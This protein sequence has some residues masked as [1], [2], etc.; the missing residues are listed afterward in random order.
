MSYLALLSSTRAEVILMVGAFA[1]LFVDLRFLRGQPGKIRRE[2]ALAFGGL[3]IAAAMASLSFSIPTT[4]LWDGV[5]ILDPLTKLVKLVILALAL[6]AVFLVSDSLPAVHVGEYLAVMF[7]GTTGLLLLV[8]TED[9]VMLFIALELTSLSLYLL[10]A[11]ARNDPLSAE[12]ALKYFLFGSVS[13]AFTL[14]GISLL[15]G[16]SGS[17]NLA[18]IAASLG[19]G[20][21]DSLLLVA[22]AM[23]IM[24]LAFKVAAAPLHLWAPD[25]YQGAP[26]SAAAFIASA[27]KV[28][29]FFIFARVML[30]GFAG[31]EGS[32]SWAGMHGGWVLVFAGLSVFSMVLGNFTAL[33]QVSVRR[34]LAYS[35]VAHAG[36]ALL[37]FIPH[38]SQGLSA[39]LYYVITYSLAVAGAFGVVAVVER[40]RGEDQLPAYSGLRQRSPLLAACMLI[41]ILSLAGIPPLPGFFGKFY[42]FAAAVRAENNFGLLWL[43]IVAITLSAL[44]LY[45]Y[46]KVLKQI[47]VANPPVQS[48]PIPLSLPLRAAFIVL[49]ATVLAAGCLPNLLVA[50]LNQAVAGF[51]LPAP[52]ADLRTIGAIDERGHALA[53][54]E[55][56]YQLRIENWEKLGNEN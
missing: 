37:G 3:A 11:F 27:S 8:S 30:I 39:L 41:F 34:L 13:A 9:L 1:F 16:L 46:L 33:A 5:I 35:A 52:L 50:P 42:L 38:N 25:A 12:A 19:P 4:R 22:M 31:Q 32:A 45:Y 54:W 40:N 49:A 29:S 6:W 53:P 28:G 15:Y 20:A 21:P 26:T 10:T 14:F 55:R 48:A 56:G 23:V 18:A 43:V 36:Y 24:G 47:Y 2:W 44:S 51:A 17:T 7:L